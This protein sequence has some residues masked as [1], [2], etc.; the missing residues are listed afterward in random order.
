LSAHERLGA[1]SHHPR[2]AVAYKY[3]PT[4]KSTK[5]KNITV[6][7]GRTGKLTPIA[8]LETVHLAGTEVSR[9]SLHNEDEVARKDV[10]VGDTVLVEKAGEI[11]PQVVKVIK[12]K[13]TGNE[14][15]FEMPK[16]CPVCGSEAKRFGDE[17]ARKC[18]NA[19]CPAQVKQR[20]EHWGHRNAMNI[21]G[22]GPKLLDKLVEQGK[23]HKISEIYTLSKKEL[24]HIERMGQKSAQNLLE[25]IE[26]SK[27]QGLARVLY[28][29]GIDYVGQHIAR[30]LTEHYNSIED[31]MNASQQE[32]ERIEEIGGKIAESIVS[33]LK[34]EKNRKLIKDLQSHGVRMQEKEQQRAQFLEGKKFVFTGALDNY[35][36]NEASEVIREFGGRVTSSVSGETDYVVVGNRPGS[37][38]E[39]AKNQDT[40]ILVEEE[41]YQMIENEE[42][43]E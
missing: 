33:F 10:R 27:D 17:V 23:V 31:I 29:L 14:K 40:H 36:R 35:T 13:R 30:V 11:I 8:V 21:K 26:E 18:I 16:K 28:G 15:K 7:V 32:L 3:P 1:T 25:E 38:L 12:V 37:K 19:Q 6:H 39:E 20:L 9:A 2:W 43:P 42:L 4:R 24:A 41:F 22:L 34:E 5:I